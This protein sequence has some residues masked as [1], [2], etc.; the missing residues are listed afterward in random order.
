MRRPVLTAILA[1]MIVL[2]AASAS[3]AQHQITLGANGGYTFSWAEL[4][5]EYKINDLGFGAQFGFGYGRVELAGFGRYYFPLNELLNLAPEYELNLYAGVTP[6]LLIDFLPSSAIGFGL[7][8]GPGIDFRW[9]HLRVGA[10][11]GY[12]F[13]TIWGISHG[14]YTKAGIGYRF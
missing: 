11:M 7:K 3:L 5:L 13:D 4:E 2:M 12:R 1:S 8:V 9:D 6:S 10:E 14:F